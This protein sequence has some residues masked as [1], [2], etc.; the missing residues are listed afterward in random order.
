[1]KELEDILQHHGVKGMKWGKRKSTSSGS[2][3]P[4]KPKEPGRIKKEINSLKRDRQW[5]KVAGD[6]GKMTTKD[7]H[8][9]T[10]RISLENEMKRLSPAVS[11]RLRRMSKGAKAELKKNRDDFLRRGKM[12]NQELS[13][14]VN[15]LRAK[16]SLNRAIK[17]ATKSQRELGLRVVQTSAS[18]GIK[19]ALTGKVTAGD[20]FKAATIKPASTKDQFKQLGRDQFDKKYGSKVLVKKKPK[21]K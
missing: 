1:M 21:S 10:R 4:K 12:S 19:Y 7:I 17:D 16:E 11:I 13:R 2:T 18:L 15:R 3:T 14:K 8:N 6:V 5:K 20:A 9:L